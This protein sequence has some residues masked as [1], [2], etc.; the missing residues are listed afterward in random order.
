MHHLV[1]LV[2]NEPAVIKSSSI[3]IR[4]SSH[5]SSLIALTEQANRPK[6]F[7]LLQPSGLTS[8]AQKHPEI[9]NPA[10]IAGI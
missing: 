6:C 2:R 9:A 10:V 3:A 4:A 1:R 7:K 5:H 8:K